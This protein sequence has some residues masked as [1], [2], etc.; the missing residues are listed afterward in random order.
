MRHN[1][2]IVS[3]RLPVSVIRDKEGLRFEASSGGLATAMSSLDQAD[4]IW[5]GWPG[6]ASDDLSDDERR[7]IE[8]ELLTQGFYPVFL[9]AEQI[10]LFY[11]GFSN[12]TLWPLFHYFQSLTHHRNEYWDAYQEVNQLFA[13]A[14]AK[15]SKP[16][17]SVWVHDYHLMTMPGMLRSIQPNVSIGFFLHIPFPSFEIYRLLPQRKEILKG[18]LG[19]D[20]IGFHVYDYARHFLSS[21]LRLL[22]VSSHQGVLEYEG[23]SIKTDAYPIGIDYDKFRAT[24]GLPATKKSIESLDD[25]YG[26]DMKLIL[27]VDRLDYSKGIPE[28]LEA[29]RILLHDYPQWRGKVKLQMVAVPSRTEVKTYQDLREQIEQTVSRINGEYGTVDWAPISYQFQNR[30]FEE[31]VALYAAADVALVTPIRDGMNLV[32]KEYVASKQGRPGVLIL[33]EMTGAIDELPEALSIN[34]SNTRSVAEAM[35]QAL[36][37]SRREQ[38]RRLTDMQRR[39]KTY[40][41]QAW[42]ADFMDDL[43]S[44]GG[45]NESQHRKRMGGEDRAALINDFRQSERRLIL[46]DY[47]GT[48][49]GFVSSPR[50]LLAKPS[51]GLKRILK[52]LAEDERNH[53]A[54]V[55]GRP[56]KAL[57]KW[58]RGL[59]MTLVAEHGAWTRYD[60][61]WTGA[62]TDFR[63][64]KRRLKPV[65]EKYVSRTAGA[66]VEEKDYSLVWHYR[67]VA[68]ELAYVRAGEMKRELI[69]LIGDEDVGVHTGNKVIEIKPNGINKGYAAAELEALYPSDFILCAGDDYTDED[70]FRELPEDS[71]TVKVGPGETKARLQL[72]DVDSVVGLLDEL[73]KL[74]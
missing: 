16:E 27:S 62:D 26:K 3:N 14:A 1:L 9:T 41:V 38:L 70:M 44:A 43:H 22:G 32:A 31:V 50:A 51:I 25:M 33:S 29:F 61:K 8:D 67:N 54:I 45:N 73:S 42:G 4:K 21:C 19:A 48:L 40:T 28:R 66:E 57:E 72:A 46:L 17:G 68:P 69:E 13:E 52:R 47:D 71:Y 39:L 30:P 23:R 7:Q 20:L 36:V 74:R 11:E 15:V 63:Q 64:L 55:S 5:V 35:H 53:I 18:L 24:L 2:V 60:G 6:I 59:N 56:K 65:L 12:D 10:E 37:M 49:K 58:F 34:P